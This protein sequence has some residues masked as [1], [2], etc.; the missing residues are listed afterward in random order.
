[1]V[2]VGPGRCGTRV[3]THPTHL[4]KNGIDDVDSNIHKNTFVGIIQKQYTSPNTTDE[5]KAINPPLAI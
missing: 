2:G 3:G 4:P 5:D 1:V